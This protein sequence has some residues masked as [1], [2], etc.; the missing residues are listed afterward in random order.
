L[1]PERWLSTRDVGAD[2]AGEQWSEERVE[3]RRRIRVATAIGCA[4]YSW[5]LGVEL[6]RLL[7]GSRL[8]R[9][10][11]LA[12]DSIGLLLCGSLLAC[13]LS[14]RVSDRSLLR[15][16]LGLE[17][18]LALLISVT[19]PWAGFL[20]TGHLPALTWVVPI[21]ILFPLLVPAPPRTVLLVSLASVAL[22]P[23]GI[24]LL[25]AAGRVQA[26]PTDLLASA[27][28]GAVGAAIAV[29]ASNTVHGVRR[30]LAVARRL[31]SYELVERLGEGGMGEVWRA[32]HLMLARPA[33][34]KLI[35]PERLQ[36]PAEA[37]EAAIQ[38]FTREAQVTA[39]LRSPHTVE[40][41]DFGVGAGGTMYYAMELL[42]GMNLEHFVYRHGPVDPRRAVHWLRQACHS[43]GEAHDRELAH[44]DLKP[45]NLMVCTF[46][47]ERDFLKV[48]DFGLARPALRAEETRLTREGAWLGTPGWM[49]P[50]QVYEGLAGPRADLYALGCV[51]YW[52]LAGVRPFE[53]DQVGELLRQHLQAVPPPPSSRA[54]Q[55]IPAALEEIVLDCL[56]KDPARRP[57]DADELDA[58]LARSVPGEPWSQADAAAWWQAH[59]PSR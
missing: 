33:A 37:R 5:F 59:A 40:L 48:L 53:S 7:G 31:G 43:L 18:L 58:R 42:D 30:R 38:R 6:T 55:P 51:G 10:I 11:D 54:S 4:A 8:E 49:A 29:V 1:L 26:S 17:L 24:A 57:R 47:R 3:A 20:R 23:G 2:V 52:M 25:S 9:L 27:S 34:I 50:E 56:A 15:L 36:A 16:A 45:A 44:R 12:H 46:G 13:S 41:F 22:M 32:R 19:V 14:P 39:S 21:V 28:A 35:L